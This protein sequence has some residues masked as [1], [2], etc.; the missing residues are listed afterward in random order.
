LSLFSLP[1]SFFSF[2]VVFFFGG[3]GA[4]SLFL[5][6]P[7]WSLCVVVG[8]FGGLLSFFFGLWFLSLS[9]TATTLGQFLSLWFFGC[10]RLLGAISRLVVLCG[11][12]GRPRF[13]YKSC[14]RAHR[15]GLVKASSGLSPS[16]SLL[17]IASLSHSLSFSFLVILIYS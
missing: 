2:G 8:G 1:C 7:S 13:A 17:S 6:G 15:R 5:F 3:D 10:G 16:L 4:I 11:F 9:L 14:R 12:V